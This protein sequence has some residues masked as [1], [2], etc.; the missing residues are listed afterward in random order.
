MPAAFA[1]TATHAK[2]PKQKSLGANASVQHDETESGTTV[3]FL[4]S[5]YDNSSI[6]VQS[7][8]YQPDSAALGASTPCDASDNPCEV[9][10]TQ[11]GTMFV[12][13]LVDGTQQIASA[14]VQSPCDS[15]TGDSVLDAPGVVDALKTAFY[16]SNPDAEAGTGV[17]HEEL[18]AIFRRPDGTYFTVRTDDPNATE[19]AAD[20]HL[21]SRTPPAGED[22]ATF[23]AIYHTHPTKWPQPTYGCPPVGGVEYAQNK[24]ETDKH[25]PGAYPDNPKLGGGSPSDWDYTNGEPLNGVPTGPLVVDYVINSNHIWKLVPGTTPQNNHLKYKWKKNSS[26]AHK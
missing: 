22:S 4:A 1:K 9:D 16:A 19:C 7:W 20:P 12:T 5:T 6:T 3:S 8:S 14:H 25:A 21:I 18:G 15:T 2:S 17:K 26:C 13:A 23:V 10:V 24:Y 11:P